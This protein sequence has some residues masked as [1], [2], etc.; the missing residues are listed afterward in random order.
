MS[1]DKKLYQYLPAIHQSNASLRELLVVFAQHFGEL[2]QL[3]TN[4]N[5]KVYP[6]QANKTELDWLASWVDLE[7]AEDWDEEKKR[8]LLLHVLALYH[9]RGTAVGLQSYLENY[10]SLHVTIQEVTTRS[11]FQIGVS[12]RIGGFKRLGSQRWLAQAPPNVHFDQKSP[13]QPVTTYDYYIVTPHDQSRPRAV[14][15]ADH[16]KRIENKRTGAQSIEFTV[17]KM[18]GACD[19]YTNASIVRR[20]DLPGPRIATDEDGNLYEYHGD[21]LDEVET[22][23]LIDVLLSGPSPAGILAQLAN[24]KAWLLE[25]LC[26]G[27]KE[28][29]T[30]F[31]AIIQFLQPQKREL[32][33]DAIAKGLTAK[34][35]ELEEKFQLPKTIRQKSAFT[36]LCRLECAEDWL[37]AHAGALATEIERYQPPVTAPT[38]GANRQAEQPEPYEQE[39]QRLRAVLDREKPAHV[40][41][42]LRFQEEA[43]PLRPTMQIGVQS[44]IGVSTIIA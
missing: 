3:L 18:D 32:L 39:I 42:I 31:D 40:H 27:D 41:Y 29:T 16:V 33:L 19:T 14:Y 36:Q 34:E 43:P 30:R 2:D 38:Q 7:L 24:E 35:E 28:T 5:Q 4:S 22:P 6:K 11:S 23:Y 21:A 8:R 17:C 25:A 13:D 26:A 10:T 20:D 1:V 37:R 12:S 15:R 9:Q 44:R